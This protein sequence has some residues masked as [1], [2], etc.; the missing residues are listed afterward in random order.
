M[1]SGIYPRSSSHKKSY[2]LSIM[3]KQSERFVP[4]IGVSFHSRDLVYIS[5][6]RIDGFQ[7]YL[8]SFATAEIAARIYDEWASVFLGEFAVLNFPLSG[9]AL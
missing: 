8:G 6:I 1:S 9:C 5:R 2:R 3:R 4:F 7:Y